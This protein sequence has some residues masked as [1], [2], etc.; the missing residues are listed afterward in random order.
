MEWRVDLIMHNKKGQSLI[1]ILVVI[2]IM[3]IVL[4]AIISG[5]VVSREGRVQ[6]QRRLRAAE[7]MKETQE[8]VR[9]IRENGWSNIAIDNTYHPVV[10]GNSWTLVAGSDIIDGMTREIIV[11]SVYRE[12]GK[13]VTSG[14][15][16]D[17]S[18][19]AITVRIAWNQPFPSA[20]QSDFYLTRY[21]ENETYIQTRKVEDF[22][23]GT[24]TDVITTQDDDG[25]VTLGAGGSGSWCAPSTPVEE[26][27]LP[28]NGVANALTAIGGLAF[29]TTGENASGV[30]FA[31]I[32]ITTNSNPP[33]ASIPNPGTFDGYK[34]NDVFGETNYA[35]IAT[36]TNDEEIVII[37]LSNMTKSGWF[38]ASGSTDADSVY[39]YNNRGYMTQGST[40]RIFDLSSKSGSRSQL[41]SISLY[42]TGT[43]I[44]VQN[45]GGNIYA[46]VSIAGHARELQSINVTNPSSPSTVGYADV[47]GQAAQDVTVNDTGTR[48][49]L[50]TSASASQREFFIIDITSKTGSRP[51]VSGGSYDTN[52]MSPKAV[53]LVPGNKAIVVGQGAEEYQVINIVDENSPSRCGGIEINTGI[54]DVASVLESEANGGD[55]YSYILTGDTSTEFKIIEGGPGGTFSNS[56][57]Y[58][59]ATFDEIGYTTAFNRFLATTV[60][61]LN[62]SINFQIAIADAV[63]GNCSGATF[64]FTGP[65]GTTDTYYESGEAIAL[66]DDGVGYENPG[67]C[68]R[69][70]AYLSTD[71][72][73]TAPILED[74]TINYSL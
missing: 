26:L 6:Q 2:A 53:T 25:E 8:I 42:A 59:S 35:Y 18:T 14:G 50:I 72:S 64:V 38:N 20:V 56:G 23:T 15:S 61:P 1:E 7:I 60:E 30:S 69:Y 45:D 44:V 71:D 28:K 57:T 54:N 65:D 5:F 52:G 16:L 34:T 19:K 33:E 73:N 12:N 43:S 29:A 70:R 68:F 24:L 40:L 21:L 62:T 63:G 39:V 22:D 66:N 55:A 13:I 58:E 36:D 48:A 10:S 49:Y 51:V 31:K 27:D 32:N 46:Y 67:R 74:V 9:I 37:N 3:S 41:G 11:T 17:P 4:P 47:N